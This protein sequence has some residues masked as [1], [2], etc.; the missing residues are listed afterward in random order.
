MMW[1]RPSY[2]TYAYNISPLTFG[3][4]LHNKWSSDKH[5]DCST[6]STMRR[7][8]KNS[9]DCKSETNQSLTNE[10]RV[11][12]S[13][14]NEET[15]SGSCHAQLVTEHLESLA[16]GR[17]SRS[18]AV[19]R[20]EHHARVSG[21]DPRHVTLS[22]GTAEDDVSKKVADLRMTPLSGRDYDSHRALTLRGQA[23]VLRLKRELDSVVSSSMA[24]N[25]SYYAKSARQLAKEA[26][27]ESQQSQSGIYRKI[28][29]V[30]SETRG[31]Q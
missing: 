27:L 20:A 22:R 2:R 12:E 6:Q 31:L 29:T 18:G 14:T 8:Y 1:V 23:R 3:E 7:E 10:R 28:T 30:V 17:R 13:L 5:Q 15:L 24:F 21:Q 9:L 11:S 19:R 4:R 26:E 16:Q 25:R